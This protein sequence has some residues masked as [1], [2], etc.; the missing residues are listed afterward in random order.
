MKKYAIFVFAFLLLACTDTPEKGTIVIDVNVLDVTSGQLWEHRDVV[1]DSGIIKSIAEHRKNLNAYETMVDGKG[2]YLMPGLSEMHAHIPHPSKNNDQIEDVLF[3]YLAN[4]IT[5]VRGM[6]GHPTHLLLRDRAESGELLSPRIFTSSPSLNGKSVTSVEEAIATVT[7]YKKD[8]YD[9]LKIHPGIKRNVFDQIVKTANELG[10]AIAGHVPVDVGIRHALKSKYAS[11]DHIDGFLEGLV[12]ES[13]NA[14]PGE[15]GFFGYAFTPLADPSRIDTLVALAKENKVWVVPTQSLFERWFAPITTD[16]LLQEPEMK[17]MPTKTLRAWKERK[18]ATIG[19]ETGFHPTQWKHF[20]ALRKQLI[21]KLGEDG[22]GLLLGS[23]APQVFNVPGFSIHREI[24]GLL[25]AGLTPLEIIQSG[26][27][28]PAKFFNKEAVFGQVKEGFVADLMLLN[29]N[30]LDNMDHLKDLSGV[31][32]QG[33]FI[34]KIDINKRLTAI[35]NKN[36][37]TSD[38]VNPA[39]ISGIWKYYSQKGKKPAPSATFELIKSFDNGYWS[40]TETNILTNKLDSYQG[41]SYRLDG[42]TYSET[43]TFANSNSLY[44]LGETQAFELEVK[45]DTLIETGIDTNKNEVWIR[46]E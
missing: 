2:K 19:P 22:H 33:H 38:T 41:G 4:G 26:T 16:S 44:L 8:G 23:D 5:T 12:P 46:M 30:P 9:F 42:S 35:A 18:N 36:G 31:F 37:H 34:P 45:G 24:D 28:N 6:L 13:A 10:I 15:N 25:E 39:D 21:R 27:V 1:I 43:T 29:A 3:L 20:D 17:Y 11:I 40:M 32:R 7:T 14:N